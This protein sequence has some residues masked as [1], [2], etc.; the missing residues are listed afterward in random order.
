MAYKKFDKPVVMS[1]SR[2]NEYNM[3]LMTEG[4]QKDEFMRNPIGY[5]G[6]DK[7][8]GVLFKWEDVQVLGD[9]IVG[10]PVVNMDH[11]RAERTWNELQDG[12]LNA[13]SV[14]KLKFLE[15]QLEDN[16]EDP[17][18]PIL[19]VTKWYNKECSMVDNP[20][21][22]GAMKAELADSDGEFA[23]EDI[24]NDL[25]KSRNMRT[26]NLSPKLMQLLSLSDDATQ[27]A[28]EAGVERLANDN[29]Q[30]GKDKVGLEERAQQA[31]KELSDER[32]AQVKAKVTQ[33]LDGALEAKKI[34]AK[35]R[36]TLETLFA[37]KPTELGDLLSDM[38]AYQS[39]ADTLNRRAGDVPTELADKSWDDL[40]KAG[41]L[42]RVKAEFPD[43]YKAKFKDAFGK[44]P[45]L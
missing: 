32:T 25:I 11:P 15:Y 30:L 12:F 5:Y 18:K 2:V 3:R 6:H 16:P 17:T 9:Q 38:P 41:E 13:A 31:E 35:Q 27:E 23:L 36:A 28:F 33:L 22:R 20:G 19:K 10:Y 42:A 8:D 14:G 39:I 7:I 26:I 24:T 37:E 21:N 45:V 29:E 4:W 40:D 34:T 43:L 1:D 44:E